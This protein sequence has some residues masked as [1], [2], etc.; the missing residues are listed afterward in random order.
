MF[1]FFPIS[2]RIEYSNTREEKKNINPSATISQNSI[3]PRWHNQIVFCGMTEY[4]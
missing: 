3:K 2:I 1:Y 4:Y